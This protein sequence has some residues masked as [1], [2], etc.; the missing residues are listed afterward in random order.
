MVDRSHSY[1]I[2]VANIPIAAATYVDSMELYLCN[3]FR[4]ED[5]IRFVGKSDSHVFGS[6]IYSE[7]MFD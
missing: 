4:T 1:Q 2:I 3:F 5:K 6:S 7:I